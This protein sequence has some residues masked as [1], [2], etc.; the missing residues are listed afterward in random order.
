ML[1]Q[2]HEGTTSAFMVFGRGR[3]AD[4]QFHVGEHSPVCA[5]PR[6]WGSQCQLARSCFFPLRTFPQS[7]E[8]VPVQSQVQATGSW[9]AF[10]A[11]DGEGM[12]LAT[13]GE[14][15]E[16]A[17][18]SRRRGESPSTLAVPA[19][20]KDRRLTAKEHAAANDRSADHRCVYAEMLA[21]RDEAG[22]FLARALARRRADEAGGFKTPTAANFEGKH[23]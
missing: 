9:Q 6:T 1:G 11:K 18:S 14:A 17:S 8:A 3:A 7:G 19:R 2:M 20:G 22:P 23:Y 5:L 10:A 12:R 16:S 4:V 15:M 21:A 13:G